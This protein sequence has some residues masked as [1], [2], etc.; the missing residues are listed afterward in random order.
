MFRTRLTFYLYALR[1]CTEIDYSLENM[2][3]YAF[4]LRYVIFKRSNNYSSFDFRRELSIEIF[5]LG[6]STNVS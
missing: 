2:F 6:D 1:I 4:N 5:L 3:G